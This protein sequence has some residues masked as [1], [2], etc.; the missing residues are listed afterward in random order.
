[1]EDYCVYLHRRGTTGEIFYVGKGNGDR[2]WSKRGRNLWWNRIVA[3]HGFTV[4]IHIGGLQE[5]AAFEIERDMIAY[6]GRKDLGLGTLVNATDGGNGVSGRFY[7][8]D[9]R[10]KLSA[11][12]SKTK[13]PCADQ[14]VYT[15]VNIYTGEES[16]CKRLEHEEKYGIN[17]SNLFHKRK[18]LTSNDWCL[19]EN[20]DKVKVDNNVY[21]FVHIETNERFS[22]TRR[23]FQD[24]YKVSIYNLFYHATVSNKWTLEDRLGKRTDY[25]PEVYNFYHQSGET[26]TGTRIE[27]YQKYNLKIHE[28]FTKTKQGNERKIQKGWSLRPNKEY[29]QGADPVEYTFVHASGE[30]FV[31]TR[32][33]F[34]K[35]FG[36]NISY[37]FDKNKREQVRGWKVQFSKQ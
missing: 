36:F 35:K 25:C 23:E 16:T 18:S 2:P 17:V 7:T 13:H 30:V 14:R 21:N 31:G 4:E 3:K 12:L 9:Q 22:G 19:K 6:Y 27:F 5:W 8:E 29:V 15:F 32:V 24:K 1:M 10:K 26:F 34:R 11:R 33:A 28:L 20:I 37:L